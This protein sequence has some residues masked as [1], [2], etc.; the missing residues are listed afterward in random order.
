MGLEPM[1]LKTLQPWQHPE[2]LRGFLPTHASGVEVL[3]LTSWCHN[4]LGG[5]DWISYLELCER[6]YP[7]V[8][9][10]VGGGVKSSVVKLLERAHVNMLMATPDPLSLRG[11]Q[12]WRRVMEEAHLPLHSL[13]LIVNK[14]GLP[15]GVEMEQWQ[16]V[17]PLGPWASLPYD[18]GAAMRA[19]RGG[20]PLILEASRESAGRALHQ[21]ALKVQEHVQESTRVRES[22]LGASGLSEGPVHDHELKQKVHR[23]L[24]DELKSKFPGLDMT[25]NVAANTALREH[26]RSAIEQIFAEEAG[27]VQTR[28]RRTRL[29]QEIVDEALGL[30]PLEDFLRDPEVTEIMVN[31]KDDVFVER[32]GKISK[33]DRRF[34]S[35][36]HLLGVIE[37]IVVPI[38]R[39]IDESVPLVDAR[40]PDGS[41][42]N[43]II[44]PLALNGPTLTIRKFSK[45]RMTVEDLVNRGSL[46]PTML[47][48]LRSAVQR[49]RNIVV[50]GGTGSGKTTLL[51]ALSNF[52]PPDERIVTIEDAAELRLDQPHVVRLEARPPNIEGKGAITIRDLVKNA[53]RMRPDRIIIGECRGGE[54][55]DMLQAM[56]TG[57]DGS[58]TTVHA[59][60][61]KDALARIETMVL[62]AGMDLPLKAVREQVVSAIHL[63]VQVSRME[64][65]SRKVTHLAEVKGLEGDR[66][67]IDM[68]Q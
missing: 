52:I 65:G 58:L 57:H 30:G 62:M 11:V 47:E 68:I 61:P 51:N 13:A 14:S 10:D 4:H 22:A 6:A 2:L 48:A 29:I 28:E 26:A 42:V 35:D 32:R 64:D 44:P 16:E 1:N 37:R 5:E 15:D 45:Q 59:N 66:I 46:S 49:R 55:L 33:V 40:L 31:G 23:R 25:S 60:T 63:V 34:D 54:A 17:W 3:N 43:A 53:L 38:G 56:N 50:S 19:L 9:V 12:A 39:R 8:V 7:W 41:R 20:T 24:V 18:H 27:N 36:R 21:L 67:Q